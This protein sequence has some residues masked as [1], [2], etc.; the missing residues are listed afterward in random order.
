MKESEIVQT[1]TEPEEKRNTIVNDILYLAN[2][3]GIIMVVIYTM[4]GF[5][6]FT[7]IQLIKGDDALKLKKLA[8]FCVFILIYIISSKRIYNNKLDYFKSSCGEIDTDAT[9]II[10]TENKYKVMFSFVYY[11]VLTFVSTFVWSILC[12]SIVFC[13]FCSFYNVYCRQENEF[14]K[15]PILTIKYDKYNSKI[16][17]SIKII[18][19]FIAAIFLPIY[20]FILVPAR[21]VDKIEE[22][23]LINKTFKRVIFVGL[24]VCFLGVIIIFQKISFFIVKTNTFKYLFNG[25]KYTDI[26][27]AFNPEIG[28]LYHLQ[29]FGIGLFISIIY[30]LFMPVIENIDNCS[31]KDRK[32]FGNMLSYG[33]LIISMIVVVLYIIRFVKVQ[34]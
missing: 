20:T 7:I 17:Y 13:I 26:F 27:N 11:Y 15:I 16:W 29:I 31:D 1:N 4:L 18:S 12:F 23:K 14:I 34:T 8:G 33:Y 32:W 19:L 2:Y 28:N 21:F 6:I 25:L 5:Y 10:S 9:E 30:S 24:M 22:K 3:N